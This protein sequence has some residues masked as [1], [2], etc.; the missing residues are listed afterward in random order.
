M[1]RAGYVPCHVAMVSVSTPSRNGYV[2]LAVG[3]SVATIE[4]A[5]VVI[6]V[7]T[8]YGRVDLTGK[9]FA[10]TSTLLIKIAHPEDR[11]QLERAAYERFGRLLCW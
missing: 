8:E 11:E 1:Y 5:D 3:C 4:V 2:S 9:S 10:R 7:I 6:G